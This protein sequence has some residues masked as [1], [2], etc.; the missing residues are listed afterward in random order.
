ME[1]K[2]ATLAANLSEHTTF[3]L[4]LRQAGVLPHPIKTAKH[5]WQFLRNKYF[6]MVALA[7]A[8]SNI[9]GFSALGDT[10]LQQ[11]F[12]SMYVRIQEA[13][14]SFAIDRIKDVSEL[15]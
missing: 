11:Q 1:Y 15:H 4:P 10:E 6:I 5:V 14:A 13:Q 12:A 8:R 3:P 9:P 2:S 7:K